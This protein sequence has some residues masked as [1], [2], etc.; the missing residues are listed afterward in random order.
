M[1]STNIIAYRKEGFFGIPIIGHNS[2]F[3][4][5]FDTGATE[6]VVSVKN[7]RIA[8]LGDDFIDCCGLLREPHG[9]IIITGF[10]FSSYYMKNNVISTDEILS[11]V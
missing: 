6:A 1:Q 8:L 10:D 3:A 2:S 9:N 7:R 4:I 5:K 11:L